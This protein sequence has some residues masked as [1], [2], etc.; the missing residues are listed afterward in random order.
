MYDHKKYIIKLLLLSYIKLIGFIVLGNRR[1]IKYQHYNRKICKYFLNMSVLA[2]FT[3]PHTVI[4]K[5]L[6][7]SL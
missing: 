7:V 5:K 6:F 3:K 1:K 4:N 2:G